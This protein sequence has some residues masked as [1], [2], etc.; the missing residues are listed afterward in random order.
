MRRAPQGNQLGLF[1]DLFVLV[2]G[3]VMGHRCMHPVAGMLPACLSFSHP[4][5]AFPCILC[6]AVG[7]V[8]GFGLVFGGSD[9]IVWNEPSDDFPY[10]KGNTDCTCCYWASYPFSAHSVSCLARG[11]LVPSTYIDLLAHT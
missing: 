9:A 11:W 1:A 7:A 8:M 6:A 4:I 3:R 10:R 2:Q 5:S